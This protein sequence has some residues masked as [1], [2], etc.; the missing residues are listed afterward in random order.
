MQEKLASLNINEVVDRTSQMQ[1]EITYN[2]GEK[3]LLH[4]D[5][6][7]QKVNLD[8]AINGIEH[9]IIEQCS[10][11]RTNF[12]SYE[13]LQNLIFL[14][15]SI[16][17]TYYINSITEQHIIDKIS[18][19]EKK[20]EQEIDKLNPYKYE[21]KETPIFYIVDRPVN[22]RT[23]P[24]TKSKIIDTLYPNNKVRLIKPK[25]KWIYIEY[26]DYIDGIPKLGWVYKK[27]LSHH[28]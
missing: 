18:K 6:L 8:D 23:K 4:I 26:F 12:V 11:N 28:K 10:K 25:H 13:A 21:N 9:T 2:F 22:V 19:F 5:K 7:N 3:L 14:L 17:F 16:I 1:E 15:L 24:S 27:Y 20:V